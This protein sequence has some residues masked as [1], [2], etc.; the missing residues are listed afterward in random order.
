MHQNLSSLSSR[1]CTDIL[2]LDPYQVE[3]DLK[4]SS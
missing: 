3:N 1:H 4:F 2:D